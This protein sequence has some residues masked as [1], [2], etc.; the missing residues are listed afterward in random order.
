MFVRGCAPDGW[1][2]Q[3]AGNII[4]L[5]I[6]PKFTMA[7]TRCD[8]HRCSRGL[9]RCRKKNRDGGLVDACD[10]VITGRLMNFHDFLVGFA[11]R[12]GRSVWP[13]QD[14]VRSAC[15]QNCNGKQNHRPKYQSRF[16]NPPYRCSSRGDKAAIFKM[17]FPMD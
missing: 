4:T 8:D 12:A 10:D 7:A 3:L 9:I 13:E 6:H 16:A 17:G 2:A 14:L 11:F 1:L 15:S 5:V